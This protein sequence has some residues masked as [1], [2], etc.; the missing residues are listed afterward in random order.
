MNGIPANLLTDID[1]AEPPELW[2]LLTILAEW[3]EE[4]GDLRADGIRW[5]VEHRRKPQFV[6]GRYKWFASIFNFTLDSHWIPAWTPEIG[7]GVYL[8]FAAQSAAY[9]V[10][11]QAFADAQYRAEPQPMQ[12]MSFPDP[13]DSQPW[14]RV[15]FDARPQLTPNPRT[16]D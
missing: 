13:A 1:N 9:L 12:Q 8:W 5:L 15:R 11:A 2:N 6:G 16:D 4:C 7:R 3:L 10:A 14:V